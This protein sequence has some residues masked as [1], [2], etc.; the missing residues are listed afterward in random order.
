[1]LSCFLLLILRDGIET[2]DVLTIKEAFDALD[3]GGTGRVEISK[4]RKN[5]YND[6][7]LN[8]SKND[9]RFKNVNKQRIDPFSVLEDKKNEEGTQHHGILIYNNR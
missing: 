2:N 5:G 8:R 1:M 7:F 9:T 4:L 6:E 3:Q